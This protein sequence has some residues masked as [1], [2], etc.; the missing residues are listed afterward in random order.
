MMSQTTTEFQPA[1]LPVIAPRPAFGRQLRDAAFARLRAM[2]LLRAIKRRLMEFARGSEDIIYRQSE[3]AQK[4][5]IASWKQLQASGVILPLDQVG[6]SR[7]S[8]FEEDGHLLYLLTLAGSK[9]RTV[10]EISSQ[11]GR[12][13]MA[14]NL[15]VH[16]RWRGFLFD[17]DPVFVREGRRF[18]ASHP[19]TRTAPPVMKSEWFTRENVNQTLAAAGVPDEVDVL[20]LDID[21]N[22]LYLWSAMTMRPRILICEFN[23]AVPSDLALTIPYQPDFSFADLPAGQAMF[24]SAS[25]AAYIA[26]GR[27]KGYRLVGMN[28]LGFNAIFLRDDVLTAEMP[29]IPASTLDLNPAAL[30]VRCQWWPRLSQL[31]WREVPQD[32]KL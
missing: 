18:F 14:T 25:L 22:D 16:H 30:E 4:N 32:G 13:C 11:D 27:R 5:L 28:A 19:A 10:V 8:E 3:V 26:V 20:S 9:S 21:G 6:F 23:N 15:L 12:V 2:P 7:F 1:T 17:G 31:P 29:E 24:R